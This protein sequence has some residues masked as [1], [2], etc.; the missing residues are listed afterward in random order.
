MTESVAVGFRSISRKGCSGR[1]IQEEGT[2]REKIWQNP[3]LTKTVSNPVCVFPLNHPV[4]SLSPRLPITILRPEFLT[5]IFLDFPE[6]LCCR[7]SVRVYV[8]YVFYLCLPV[9]ASRK[10]SWDVGCLRSALVATAEEIKLA[11]VSRQCCRFIS[12]LTA[13]VLLPIHRPPLA[14]VSFFPLPLYFAL[15]IRDRPL[16]VH[17]LAIINLPQC[18]IKLLRAWLNKY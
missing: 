3:L 9:C 18:L 15:A 16:S 12:L 1:N 2:W 13:P 14:P 4:L 10:A 5:F 8:T 7:S 6:H 11:C 17:V